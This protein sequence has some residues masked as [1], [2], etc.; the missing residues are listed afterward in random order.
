MIK[1]TPAAFAVSLTLCG[2]NTQA[3]YSEPASYTAPKKIIRLGDSG[4]STGSLD[5]TWVFNKAINDV[6]NAGGGKVYV[7][8]DSYRAANVQLKSNVHI[9][10][11]GGTTITLH[12]DGKPIFAMENNIANTSIRGVGGRWT[13][14][15][16]DYSKALVIGISHVRNGMVKNINVDD[17]YYTVHQSISIGWN[18]NTD[19]TPLDIT[20]GNITQDKEH[21][22]YGVM[23]SQAGTSMNFYNLKGKGGVPARFETGWKEMNLADR[24]G[25][26]NVKATNITSEYGQAAVML[27]PHTRHCG[28][29][30]INGVNTVGSEF[31]V[32]HEKG[33][34]WK[35]TAEEIAQHN[36]TTGTFGNISMGNINGVY[37]ASGVPTRW[38]HLDYF[39]ESELSKIDPADNL[40]GYIGPSIAVIGDFGIA[41]SRT[42]WNLS[43]T[44][45]YVNPLTIRSGYNHPTWKFR[46]L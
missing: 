2:L 41:D 21:Y 17:P 42:T 30:F 7:P 33:G 31:A 19:G 37:K 39:P 24:G 8:K 28:D 9:E 4:Y 46:N 35:Y 12:T 23:Q 3:F 32:L 11:Q 14:K 16:P 10:I 18:R 34:T 1:T 22:G 25:V 5:D 29:V 36:L 20:V 26:Y 38:P 13:A 43:K 40:S 27:Q 45:A 44:G 15:L 6:A